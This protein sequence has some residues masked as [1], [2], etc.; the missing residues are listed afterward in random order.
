[1]ALSASCLVVYV[2]K[3]QPARKEE[4]E[5]R[6]WLTSIYTGERER[7]RERARTSTSTAPNRFSATL[8]YSE[9]VG[10]QYF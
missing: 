5:I 9:Q 2:K 1:M 7:E 10:P 8:L 3:Q 6:N 4:V